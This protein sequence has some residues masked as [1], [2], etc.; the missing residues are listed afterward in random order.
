MI[1]RYTFYTIPIT[2]DSC[3]VEKELAIIEIPPVYGLEWS[4][5]VVLPPDIQPPNYNRQYTKKKTE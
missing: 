5:V 1:Q 2:A 4:D 3:I